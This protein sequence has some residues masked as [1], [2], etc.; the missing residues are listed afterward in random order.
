MGSFDH[1]ATTASCYSKDRELEKHVGPEMPLTWLHRML[2]YSFLRKHNH[3]ALSMIIVSTPLSFTV[4]GSKPNTSVKNSS[5]KG[6]CYGL[7]S[8]RAWR[9]AENEDECV[10]LRAS[11]VLFRCIEVIYKI[12]RSWS[13]ENGLTT[14]SPWFSF[15]SQKKK[16]RIRKSQR[17][18]KTISKQFCIPLVFISK[19]KKKKKN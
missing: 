14:I 1:H 11:R 12:T 19:K 10:I 2:I 3:T 6:E 5:I 15:L 13:A 9:V 16:K 18:F 7:A 17:L 8:T 4:K